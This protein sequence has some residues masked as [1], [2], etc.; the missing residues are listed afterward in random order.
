MSMTKV[1][2]LSNVLNDMVD[3]HVHDDIAS[4][5]INEL[6]GE[7]YDIAEGNEREQN[8]E[9]NTMRKHY[10]SIP[11]LIRFIK[12]EVAKGNMCAWETLRLWDESRSDGV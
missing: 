2:I 4:S 9:L 6:I 8:D 7:L 1:D 12:E 10:D 11:I 3:E 5:K